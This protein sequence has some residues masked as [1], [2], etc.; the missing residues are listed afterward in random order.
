MKNT[1]QENYE[2]ELIRKQTDLQKRSGH[3][4]LF[5]IVDGSAVFSVN[6]VP[7]SVR[8]GDILQAS[9]G[10]ICELKN[11][12]S[13]LCVCLSVNPLVFH[14][15]ENPDPQFSINS[16]ADRNALYDDL[17]E[18]I[19]DFLIAEADGH[20]EIRAA[21]CFCLLLD[22]M[23]KNFRADTGAVSHSQDPRIA[24]MLR[25][26]HTRYHEE[27]SLKEAAEEVFLSPSAASRLFLKGTGGHFLTYLRDYRLTRAEEMLLT[28]DFSVSKNSC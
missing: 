9:R 17:R 5:Y 18:K 16:A 28:S 15:L 22:E 24:K 26:I 10:D 12:A 3:L 8:H 6:G 20:S 27:A 7:C 2:I 1:I 19:A 4:R 14:T 13:L 21:G 25:Y 23:L 11:P